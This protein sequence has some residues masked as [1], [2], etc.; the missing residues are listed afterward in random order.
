MEKPLAG[1]QVVV[2][3]G[4]GALG[5]AVVT[6]LIAAGA[7]CHVP[8]RRPAGATGA[9]QPQ[10]RLSHGIDLVDEAAVGRFYGAIPELWASVHLAGGF[11]MAPIAE[12]SAAEFQHMFEQN[13]LSALL[14]SRAAVASMR[15]GGR[16]GR[17]VQVAA[18]QALER[19]R[20]AG[21]IAYATAKAAVAALTESLAE[22]LK[23][24]HI[25]VNAIAPSTLDPP[26]NRRAMPDADPA[27]WL[28]PEDAA[29]AILQL[30]SPGNRAISGAVLPLYARA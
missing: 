14:C 3:G 22:E 21:M 17:I 11:A 8:V 7:C 20:G 4:T 30:I 29:E 9:E 15:A 23:E 1:R 18:R 26:A 28:A 12:T 19:R 6:R 10:L 25:L 2:T 5:Q 27:G 13:A 16:G 24:E